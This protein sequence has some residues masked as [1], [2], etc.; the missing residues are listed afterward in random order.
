MRIQ[1][2]CSLNTWVT[3]LTQPFLIGSQANSAEIDATISRLRVEEDAL[4][5]VNGAQTGYGGGEGKSQ[6]RVP[7]VLADALTLSCLPTRFPCSREEYVV[8]NLLR[9][10]VHG[11]NV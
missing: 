9:G 4:K 6:K 7:L 11:T 5:P 8:D 10:V 2:L 3:N 1:P